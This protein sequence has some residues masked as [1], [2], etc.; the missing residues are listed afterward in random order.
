MTPNPDKLAE[1][2]LVVHLQERIRDLV[3]KGFCNYIDNHHRHTDRAVCYQE[4]DILTPQIEAFVNESVA[5]ARTELLQKVTELEQERDR[6][7]STGDGLA[8]VYARALKENATLESQLRMAR[9]EEHKLD[10]R[11]CFMVSP[12]THLR[13]CARRAELE[14][15]LREMEGK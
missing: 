9:L 5:L 6:W 12:R 13:P 11:A 4:A 3:A 10:C 14:A 7:R 2:R 1:R 15:N 8:G